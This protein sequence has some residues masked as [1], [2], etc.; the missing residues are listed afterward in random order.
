MRRIYAFSQSA[1][2]YLS[3]EFAS[4]TYATHGSRSLLYRSGA[5][6]ASWALRDKNQATRID[7]SAGRDPGSEVSKILATLGGERVGVE[8]VLSSARQFLAAQKAS[9]L[10]DHEAAAVLDNIS[11]QLATRLRAHDISE[12]GA[13]AT[14]LLP[15]V[16]TLLQKAPESSRV[17]L[18]L[19]LQNLPVPDE[20]VPLDEVLACRETLRSKLHDLHRWMRK[21]AAGRPTAAEI[22]DEIEQLLSDYERFMDIQRSKRRR[23]RLETVVVTTAEVAENLFKMKFSRIAQ[24]IFD[25]RKSHFALV[26]AELSAP[27]REVAY[28]AEVRDRFVG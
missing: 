1:K 5:L 9:E 19:V 6:V 14:P 24:S 8:R 28:I 2:S 20:S 12:G 26:E 17:V 10:S 23:S 18:D 4:A 16:L 7:V 25:I 3:R 27:G 15:D 11:L 21:I 13:I 22:S